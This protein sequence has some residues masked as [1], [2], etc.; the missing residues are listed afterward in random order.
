MAGREVVVTSNPDINA[1]GCAWI[2][3]AMSH[4]HARRGGGP[5]LH[6]SFCLV[7]LPGPCLCAM[8]IAACDAQLLSHR[9]APPACNACLCS[10]GAMGCW[11]DTR[12]SQP[13]SQWCSS[14][15]E[16]AY[17]WPSRPRRRT[18]AERRRPRMSCPHLGRLRSLGGFDR[19]VL[20]VTGRGLLLD[21]ERCRPLG[22]CQ[23]GTAR[24]VGMALAVDSRASLGF[25]AASGG[26]E[27]TGKWDG[28]TGPRGVG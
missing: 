19:V 11:H 9:A 22:V 8:C 17:E 10:A 2:P 24:A 3:I 20:L 21:E 15:S 25:P 18:L 6:S 4:C 14:P 1:C 13:S 28:R 7:D 26:A 16:A 12:P 5:T 23:S 27:L